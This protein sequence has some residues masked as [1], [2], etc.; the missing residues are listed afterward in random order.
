MHKCAERARE[1]GADI[2]LQAIGPAN[3]DSKAA[4]AE[5]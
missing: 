3:P 5:Q 1:M 2:R 4:N